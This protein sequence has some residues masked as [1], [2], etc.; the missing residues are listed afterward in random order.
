[1]KRRRSRNP[2]DGFTLIELLIVIA[3]MGTFLMLALPTYK[4]AVAN[5]QNQSCKVNKRM[6]I[7][8]LE[9]YAAENG[10]AYPAQA[11][12]LTDLEN[13]GYLREVPSCPLGGTYSVEISADGKKIDVKC[14]HHDASS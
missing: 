10:G 1:V 4:G 2:Q 5:A 6:V 7:T 14:S 13:K 9:V 11:T 3:I 8:A 12:A